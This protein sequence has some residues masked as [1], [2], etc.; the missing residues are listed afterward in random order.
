MSIAPFPV[1]LPNALPDD[2]LLEH[3]DWID[4]PTE[5]RHGFS[6]DI[7]YRLADGGSVHIFETNALPGDMGETDPVTL[8]GGTIV[9]V[10]GETWTAIVL[11]NG[12]GTWNTQL[13]RRIGE[14]TITIDGPDADLVREVAAQ[15][16]PAAPDTQ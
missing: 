11:P 1:R 8:S 13:A 2:A 3:V 4:S 5:D 9:E 6:I 16:Q 15:L 12:D 10:A 7:R 14:V